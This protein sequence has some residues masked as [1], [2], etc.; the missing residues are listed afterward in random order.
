MTM[1]MPFRTTGGSNGVDEW[2][3]EEMR[4]RGDDTGEGGWSDSHQRL[5]LLIKCS[6]GAL[7]L[8]SSSSNSKDTELR[9]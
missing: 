9:I 3:E 7:G 5:V 2:L 4:S 8:I 6:T 1:G